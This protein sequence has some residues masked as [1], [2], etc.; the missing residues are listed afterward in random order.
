[1]H[2]CAGPGSWRAT[3]PSLGEV[4][5]P[6]YEALEPTV[7][8]L[9]G[10]VD[11]R[12][13]HEAAPPAADSPVMAELAA[14]ADWVGGWADEPMGYSH[15]LATLRLTVAEDH[16]R[17]I[18]KLLA[19]DPP[20]V[21]SHMILARSILELTART[22]WVDEPAIGHKARVARAMTERV[23]NFR[24]QMDLPGADV[25]GDDGTSVQTRAQAKI[26]AIIGEAQARGIQVSPAGMRIADQERPGSTK[27]VQDYVLLV[28][29]E[30]VGRQVYSIYS[31]IEHGTIYGLFQNV[32]PAGGGPLVQPGVQL[33]T[34]TE[35]VSAVL[36]G[37]VLG[38]GHA[39]DNFL[40]RRGVDRAEFTAHF[41][42]AI[43][44]GGAQLPQD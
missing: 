14:E 25:I 28:A 30:D 42:A 9:Q 2:L 1:M 33:V 15:S 24:Q 38:Y 17:S 11:A 29:G 21:F 44:S 26:G 12:R 32:Q 8:A 27:A 40:Q 6:Y 16:I 31:A 36:A 39:A 10:M 5:D 41:V 3:L 13:A 4:A 23:Y 43:A 7:G 34:D 20:S 18:G 19:S 37:V 35:N 22:W